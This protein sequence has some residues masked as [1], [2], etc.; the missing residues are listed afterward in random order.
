M[1]QIINSC[2]TAL[3]SIGRGFC[4]YTAG[5]FV[6]SSVLIVML[7]L[8][9]FL[10]RKHVRAVFRY[11]VW[12]LVFVK[13]ILPPTLSLPTGI[14]YWYGDYLSTD[15]PVLQ[16]VS[17]V[18]RPKPDG[19]P[20][21]EDFALAAEISQDRLSQTNRGTAAPVTS[22]VSGLETLTWQAFVFG[23]WLVGVLVISVLLIQRMSF[24]KG[25]IAQS[26]PAKNRLVD[27]LNQCRRQVGIG[28]N[29]DTYASNRRIELRLSN[30]ISGPAVCGLFKPVILMP[31]ALIEKLSPDKLR[32][33]L[34]HEL[35][36]IK[37]ADIWVNLVQ[38]VLQIIYFY[39]PFVWLANAVVRRIREQAVD[40]MVLV[41]LGAE[42]KSY[43]NTLIDIAEMAF[44]RANLALRLIGV[45]ESKK[46]L[47]RRIKHML[48]RPIPKS[49]KLSVVG[50]FAIIL[51][52]IVLLPMARGERELRNPV[53][54][55]EN[56]RPIIT[57]TLYM[58]GQVEDPVYQLEGKIYHEVDKVVARIGELM[59]QDPFPM[60]RV[61]TTSQFQR[62]Q[63]PIERLGK[64]CRDIGFINMEYKYDLRIPIGMFQAILH[65]DVTLEL[66]GVCEHPTEGK[67]WWK[68][69]G[70]PLAKAPYDKSGDTFTPPEKSE[71]YKDYQFV[72][73]LD[74]PEGTSMKWDIPGGSWSASTNILF[75][76]NG[77]YVNNLRLDRSNQPKDK[78]SALV[79]IG[80][81]ADK[82]KTVVTYT[83]E[84]AEETYT[85]TDGAVAFGVPYEKKGETLLPV[86][87]NYNYQRFVT[88]VVALSNSGREYEASGST[89]RGRAL[90]SCTCEFNLSL[91]DIKE[92]KFQIR[93]YQWVEFKNVSLRPGMKTDVQ[94]EEGEEMAESVKNM[95][96]LGMEVADVTPDIQRRYEL[97][98]PYGVVILNPGYGH[99]RLGIG[100]LTK[101]YYFWMVGNKKIHNLREMITE[102]L[103]INANSRP[104]EGGSVG[105]G[106]EGFIRTVYGYGRARGTNTRYLKPTKEDIE[107]L[108]RAGKALGIQDEKLYYGKE[109]EMEARIESAKKLS[110]FGKALLIYAND[111]DDKY[112]VNM[113]DVNSY[114]RNK[115][116]LDWLIENIEYLGKGKSIII[117]PTSLLAYDET[118][119]KKKNCEGTNVLYNDGRVAFEKAEKLKELGIISKQKPVGQ[120]Q[121]EGGAGKQLSREQQERLE[122][123]R[124]NRQSLSYK[125]MQKLGLA[126]AVFANDHKGRCPSN[127]LDLRKYIADEKIFDWINQNVV[128]LGKNQQY[129]APPDAVL[130]YDE[131]MLKKPRQETNV[132]YNDAHVA[133]VSS[134]WLKE[135]G[136]R[137]GQ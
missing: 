126:V 17:N 60:I 3:N 33:V 6:Q 21:S 32:T 89:D 112:P 63:E 24:V 57:H 41:S 26:E 12:M 103:R 100:K 115:R 137:L 104:Q 120:V 30:N 78:I 7:L 25:L 133:L 93:S 4:D 99:E 29:M 74:C 94:V 51:A 49:A 71:E 108:R 50:V 58:W 1:N 129:R 35:V 61:H 27:M 130:A 83:P 113:E 54:L 111:H 8:I 16:Q 64:R 84:K 45:A 114:L 101:G 106:Y 117:S 47:D 31:T 119:L 105:Q 96:L 75:D 20:A 132:L 56:G 87:H 44:F 62:Q 109:K 28:R 69:D 92:F 85:L 2:L 79:R 88:R 46:S 131:S 36:H 107:E 127:L 123:L 66:V 81:A 48:N 91:K 134:K 118:L 125:N 95:I 67:Q 40:E 18:V 19:I 10:L 90:A 82:W 43:S 72:L 52:G 13:L 42:A 70:S 116:D 136:I 11:C 14:G 122:R 121:G 110:D 39:N 53:Q 76:A 68:P 102:I 86:V 38:T 55:D 22:A 59:K 128:Y 15:S 37:R 97:Y 98:H 124:A 80:V 77:N 65:N 34:I 135:I 23:L 9:D 73:Y 5:I